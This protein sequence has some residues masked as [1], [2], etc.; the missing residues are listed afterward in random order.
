MLSAVFKRLTTNYIKH[1]YPAVSK[2]A[3]YHKKFDWFS[4][5]FDALL[6]EEITKLIPRTKEFFPSTLT[7]LAYT[8]YRTA[9]NG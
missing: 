1:F 5:T 3:S 7:E 9:V 2:M 4:V 6:C 8:E